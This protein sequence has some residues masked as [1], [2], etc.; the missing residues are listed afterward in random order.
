MNAAS[1]MH[2][3]FGP[4]SN[5]S[6]RIVR[7][8]AQLKKIVE[9]C[10]QLGMRLVLT[11][12]TFDIKH[13]GHD[14]YLETARSHGD[15]LIVGVDSDDKVKK[16]K[17]PDRPI[18]DEAERTESLCHVRHVDVV[19]VKEVKDEKWQ[20]IGTVH[21]D[22]L[23]VP[24]GKYGPDEIAELERNHCGKVVILEPQA[25]TSTTARIRKVLVGPTQE[26]RSKLREAFEQADL[27]LS[28]VSGD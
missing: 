4:G 28:S 3:L 22:I 8:Y 5:P 6:G 14:R 1:R 13:I 19:F 16:R 18:V 25:T 21:P 27:F 23:I 9:A 10:R 2:D 7:D 20:L 24:A 26:I 12:G 11:S 15:L 17:G